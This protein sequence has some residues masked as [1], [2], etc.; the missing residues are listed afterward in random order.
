MGRVTRVLTLL[1]SKGIRGVGWRPIVMGF[2]AT[3]GL[4]AFYV[5]VVRVGSGSAEHLWSL[6]AEDA[7]FVAAITTGFGIQI[8]LFT[9]LRRAMKA[10]HGR[11]STA[12]AATG[13]GG[14]TVAMVACC[15]HHLADIMPLAGMTAASLLLSEYKR[16]LMTVGLVATAIGILWMLWQIRRHNQHYALAVAPQPES[17]AACH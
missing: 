3:A 11:M 1:E 8:G 2:V 9:H 4:M 13:T 15:A 6:M 12:V 17:G 10:A 14:S 16:P 7:W 5:V